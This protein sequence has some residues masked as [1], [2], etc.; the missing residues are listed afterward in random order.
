MIVI[1]IP[2]LTDSGFGRSLA[3]L[4]VSVMAIPSALTKPLCGYL[5]N[6]VL[7]ALHHSPELY[8]E[9][10]RALSDHPGIGSARD[11]IAGRRLPTRRLRDRRAD[12][13]SR[14]DLAS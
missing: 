9:C 8:G 12:P 4:M 1:T 7:G 2:Y 14:V 13:A 3:A 5:G 10:N 11:G 6:R